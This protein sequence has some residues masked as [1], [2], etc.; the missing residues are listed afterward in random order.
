MRKAVIAGLLILVTGNALAGGSGLISKPSP[1]AVPETI[2]R[3]TAV[4]QSRG[5]TIFARVDHAAEA[6]KVG[7][8]LRPTQLLVF[9]NPRGGTP[10]MGAAPTVA[11]DLPFKA[12]AWEDAGG[13]VRLAYNAPEYLKTRHGIEGM[14]EVLKALTGVLDA[15]TEEALKR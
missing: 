12:L 14:E 1:Y 2:D 9:G 7:L 5:M 4:L 13:K 15:M 11:I 8:T 3:L 10:L 6:R